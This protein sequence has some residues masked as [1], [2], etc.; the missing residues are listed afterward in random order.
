MPTRRPPARRPV[1]RVPVRRNRMAADL[2]EALDMAIAYAREAER[3]A[4]DEDLSQT[5]FRIEDALR[6]L[7]AA[8]MAMHEEAGED[9]DEYEDED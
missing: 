8:V 2:G 7:K 5:S 9:E 4:D 3:Y 1:A 6:A